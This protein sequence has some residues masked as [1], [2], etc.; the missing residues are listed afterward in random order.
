M[1][2]SED[3]LYVFCFARSNPVLDVPGN[4]V[5]GQH[6]LW[7]FH[8]SPD[9]CAVVSHVVAE[10]FCGEAAERQMQDLAWLGPRAYRHEAVIEQV[11]A[12]SP[13]LP[14]PFGTLFSSL[15]VLSDFMDAHRETI[16]DFLRR[17]AG[18]GEWSVRGAL[19]RQ[20][21]QQT[22]V[23]SC[24]AGQHEQ[25]SAMAEGTRYFA[26]QRIRNRAD[27]ELRDWLQ[28]T[29]LQLAQDLAAHAVEFRECKILS[30]ERSEDGVEEVLN[31]AFLLPDAART[32]FQR[33]LD[34]ANLDCGPRGLWFEL[35]GPWPPF[36]FVP[37]LKRVTM[38]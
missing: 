15:Q 23:S 22:A 25:L 10:D 24:L 16:L 6:P 38:P 27:D 17:V 8:H 35:S 5:D 29:S 7:I 31:W 26:E 30:R 9:L 1:A 32:A 33:R 21:A 3:A 20:L 19:N 28:Q 37:A 12:L 13:V 11:M 34:R 4:G 18:H 14:V 36:R 2:D